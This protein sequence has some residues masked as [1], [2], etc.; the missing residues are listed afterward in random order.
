MGNKQT[1]DKAVAAF[2]AHDAAQFA[3]LYADDAIVYD[4]Q[5]PEPL[6]GRAA[7]E[8]DMAD[9]YRAFPDATNRLAVNIEDGNV[10]AA[11]FSITGTHSGPLALP[12]G[13]VPA[14]GKRLTF[15]GGVFSRFNGQGLIVEEHRYYDVAGQAAQLGIA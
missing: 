5:Y 14:T 15:E 11:R 1:L 6:K 10:V 2:N 3:A 12:T 9:F 8:Q 13:E 7:V 4:P